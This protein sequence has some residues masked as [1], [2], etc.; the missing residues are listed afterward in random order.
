[1]AIATPR[2]TKR[3]HIKLYTP[4]AS[5]RIF[6]ECKARYRVLPC[7]RRWGKSLSFANEILKFACDHPGTMSAWIAPYFRQSKRFYRLIKQAIKDAIAHHSDSELRLE[8]L[9]GS[10]IEF[11]SADNPDAARSA[12]L[13]FVVFDEAADIAEYMWTHV[14]RPMLSDTNGKAVFGGTP[15]GR[16]WFYRL[17]MRG[18]D[19]L[20]SDW[21][22]HSFPTSDNPYIPASEIEEAKKDLPEDVYEQEYLAVFH[23]ESAG[24]FRGI[25]RCIEGGFLDPQPYTYYEVGWDVAKR[26]DFSVFSVL[27]LST[28]HVDYWH[29]INHIDYTIQ[30][31]QAKEITTRYNNAHMLMDVTGVG[32]AVMEMAVGAG[33]SVDGYQYA[34]N[35]KKL[36]IE[37]LIVGIEHVALTFPDIPVLINELRIMQFKYTPGR[38]IQ[39]E[40]PSGAHDDTVNSLALAYMV[41]G[42]GGS[43]PMVVSGQSSLDTMV[44]TKHDVKEDALIKR[45]EQMSGVFRQINADFN[46]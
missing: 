24:A 11:W 43:I 2:I 5:Q 34:G 44:P 4:H 19:E 21:W 20:E 12:G 31:E 23:A 38:V 30:I 1:M 46:W 42:T 10:I 18:Q 17:Y 40:A 6:H 41:A 27:N 29:R 22:S 14:V 28:M 35:G 15:K 25:D 9:N 3:L 39:Y 32:D 26:T 33:I 37:K 45:Q 36:L 8:L 7:G 13:H 16:N